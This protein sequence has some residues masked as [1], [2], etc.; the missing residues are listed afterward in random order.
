MK[1]ILR[2][3]LDSIAEIFFDLFSIFLCFLFIR[4]GPIPGAFSVVVSFILYLILRFMFFSSFRE[5]MIKKL[6]K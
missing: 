5:K 6:F 2:M 4:F 1:K 3:I